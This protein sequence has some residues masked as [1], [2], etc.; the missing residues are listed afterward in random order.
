MTI[1]A[2]ITSR[3]DNNNVQIEISSKDMQKRFYSVPENKADSF[4]KS[5]AKLDKKHSVIANTAF[6]GGIFAGILAAG[7]A[8]RKI[9]NTAI[10]WG[11]NLA[12]GIIGAGASIYG[13]SAYMVEQQ[14]KLFKAHQAKELNY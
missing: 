7:I 4:V 14:N 12:S 9:K 8:T 1:D 13:T 5:Y 10:R 6:M 3:L 11:L 2:K